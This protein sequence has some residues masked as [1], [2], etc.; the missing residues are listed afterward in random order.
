MS[1]R[2]AGGFCGHVPSHS[3]TR[4]RGEGLLNGAIPKYELALHLEP[5][6]QWGVWPCALPTPKPDSVE[7][8]SFEP[9]QVPAF[10]FLIGPRAVL[11]CTPDVRTLWTRTREPFL[12]ARIPRTDVLLTAQGTCQPPRRHQLFQC[13]LPPL[14][15]QRPRSQLEL[16]HF[17]PPTWP[18]LT[19]MP[20]LHHKAF[21][22]AAVCSE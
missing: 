6:F 20:L 16:L 17:Y 19:A 10:D 15:F 9:F 4:Q 2:S 11:D 21:L 12:G 14:Q 13:H 18:Y 1:S 3:Q 8:G 7:G 22:P 5:P